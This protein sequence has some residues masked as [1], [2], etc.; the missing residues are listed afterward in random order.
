MK[1]RSDQH[2]TA[3]H[4]ISWPGAKPR[5]QNNEHQA[6]TTYLRRENRNEREEQRSTS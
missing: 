2:Q 5:D 3:R 6:Q 4:R 1:D